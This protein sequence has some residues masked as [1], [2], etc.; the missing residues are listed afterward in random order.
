[1]CIQ[2]LELKMT[3]AIMARI[4]AHQGALHVIS[5][6]TPKATNITGQYWKAPRTVSQERYP[7][8]RASNVAPSPIKS[9]GK[10]IGRELFSREYGV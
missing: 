10:T 7:R 2:L 5:A 3:V 6:S 8:L 4:R 9:S 1:M